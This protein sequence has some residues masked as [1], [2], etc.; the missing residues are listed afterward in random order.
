MVQVEPEWRL[1]GKHSRIRNVCE[2]RSA[3]QLTV[4]EGFGGRKVYGDFIW[5]S[6]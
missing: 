2:N 6:D 5:S 4:G 3:W 1:K